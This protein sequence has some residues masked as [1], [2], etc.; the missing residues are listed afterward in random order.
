VGAGIGSGW[1]GE[2]DEDDGVHRE[3][4]SLAWHPSSCDAF[5]GHHDDLR[6]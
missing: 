2:E 1:D 6:Q 5:E 3:E 4:Q